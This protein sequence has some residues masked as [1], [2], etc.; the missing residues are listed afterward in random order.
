MINVAD[1]AG[2]NDFAGI[3]NGDAITML[4]D[5]I[6]VMTNKD[7][8]HAVFALD[9]LEQLDHLRLYGYVQ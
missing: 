6:E 5:K 2:L 3:H 7:H 8:G 9:P 1:R 4:G